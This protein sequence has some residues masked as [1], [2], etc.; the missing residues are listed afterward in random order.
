MLPPHLY[1]LRKQLT[2]VIIQKMLYDYEKSQSNLKNIKQFNKQKRVAAVKPIRNTLRTIIRLSCAFIFFKYLHNSE[3]VAR[4]PIQPQ[5]WA[6]NQKSH[7]FKKKMLSIKANTSLVENDA[8]HLIELA[9][10]LVR[11]RRPSVLTD[12]CYKLTKVR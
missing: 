2:P 5:K 11:K 3:I 9:I 10:S 6:C 8:F 4:N 7:F 1:L 12:A